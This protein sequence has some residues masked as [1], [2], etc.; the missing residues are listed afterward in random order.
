MHPILSKEFIRALERD[1][2]ERVGTPR[3]PTAASRKRW[4][5]RAR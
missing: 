3:V 4:F 2:Q 1:M 5:R